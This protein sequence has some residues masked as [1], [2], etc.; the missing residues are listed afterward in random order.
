MLP[1][2][3]LNLEGLKLK[4]MFEWESCIA[5]L[6]AGQHSLFATLTLYPEKRPNLLKN[7]TMDGHAPNG[8]VMYNNRSSA[9]ND[10]FSS[11]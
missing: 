6:L 2:R 10:N 3:Y 8:F 11:V 7:E 4:E 5:N 9:Y 1:P